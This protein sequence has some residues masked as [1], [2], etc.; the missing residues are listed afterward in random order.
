MRGALSW[1]ALAVAGSVCA[2]ASVPS[3]IVLIVDDLDLTLGG[4]NSAPSIQRLFSEQGTAFE[5]GMV[6]SP[7]T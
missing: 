2:A 5:Y 7:G 6:N 1:I 4:L 3:M